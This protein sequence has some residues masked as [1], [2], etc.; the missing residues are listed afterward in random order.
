MTRLRAVLLLAAALAVALSGCTESET[1][2]DRGSPTTRTDSHAKV[3]RAYV[4]AL[5]R[6]ELEAANWL[7]CQED[8]YPEDALGP[9]L[10]RV[11]EHLKAELGRL[12]I[13]VLSRESATADGTAFAMRLAGSERDV[14]IRVVREDG[15]YRVCGQALPE[16]K[17][18]Q[19]SARQI[20]DSVPTEMRPADLS[21]AEPPSGFR[22]SSIVPSTAF[23]EQQ[24]GAEA[25]RSLLWEA[26]EGDAQVIVGAAQ[27]S[28]AEDAVRAAA[29]AESEFGPNVMATFDPGTTAARGFRYA[30]GF[31]TFI[32]PS[33]AGPFADHVTMLF[34]KLLIT[35]TVVP[36]GHDDDHH[37]ALAA[38]D[39]LTAMG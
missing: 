31:G 37:A 9:I 25:A 24:L 7:R 23:L 21:S 5:A 38:V 14:L 4:D 22:Q 15:T 34:D 33:D 29:A 28:S 17:E 18:A 13:A 20:L 19:R 1:P 8:R 10:A 26:R 3:V 2:S 36:L 6:G 30:S 32:Q 35:I 16:A 12:E 11:V 27:Y 39:T